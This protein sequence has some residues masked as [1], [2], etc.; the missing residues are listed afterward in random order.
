MTGCMTRRILDSASNSVIVVGPN[1]NLKSFLG[2]QGH[3]PLAGDSHGTNHW[4]VVSTSAEPAALRPNRP[5][6]L[7]AMAAG[8]SES[9]DTT[10]E[11]WSAG[12]GHHIGQDRAVPYL[13]G[14]RSPQSASFWMMGTEFRF[15]QG[16]G[17]A[18]PR[19]RRLGRDGRRPMPPVRAQH[20]SAV[21]P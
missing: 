9:S 5:V 14:R 11:P 12:G 15:R 2:D 10:S 16:W 6:P 7:S 1:K 17:F 18:G 13:F 8:V 20:H 4:Q 3:A 21:W 19:G